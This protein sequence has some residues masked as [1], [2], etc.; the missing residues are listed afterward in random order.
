MKNHKIQASIDMI[1]SKTFSGLNM[2]ALKYLLPMWMS[3][4]TG[5]TFRVVFGAI[6]FWIIG[7]F[8]KEQGEVSKK[9][10]LAMF[11]LGA[12][13]IYGFMMT[14][15]V[16]LSYTTPVSSS[17]ILALIPIWVFIISLFRHTESLTWLKGI[18]MI[19]GLGGA[20]LSMVSKRDPALAS[21]P[22][23]GDSI[24]LI[25]SVIYAGYLIYSHILLKKI[26]IYTLLKWTFTGASFSAI[27]INMFCGF[28]AKVLSLP[29]HLTPILALLFVLIFPTV[30]SYLLLPYGLKYLKTTVVAMY[31]YII[32]VVATIAALL[33]GQ[34]K[35]N[36]MQVFSILFLCVGVYL[37]EAAESKDKSK[38]PTTHNS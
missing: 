16:G 35:F 32:I 38:T 13:G 37:V 25:S 20:M 15:L 24:T 6:A 2:N 9:D 1:I 29:L 12:I 8:M 31:G 5:V 11:L 3:P 26:G 14:Y 17:I 33:L 10:I 19:V 7:L 36:W 21:H 34:D 30:V 23:L 18:G 22:F 28:D 4:I 27:L